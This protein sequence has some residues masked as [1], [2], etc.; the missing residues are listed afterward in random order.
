MAM[1]SVDRE[2][3]ELSQIVE[4]KFADLGVLERE[5]IQEWVV[6]EPT[7]L[8]EELLVIGT[9]YS[10]FVD[11]YER[12]DVIALDQ[13]GKLVIIELKRDQA[14]STT[15][16]Q[17]IKYA[18]YL[19]T[20]PAE[21]IQ[22]IYREFWNDRKSQSLAPE[23]VG[24]KFI[25]FLEDAQGI[26]IDTTDDGWADFELDN[27]P[28]ILLAAGSFGTEVTSPVMWLI[29]EYEMDITCVE[30][31]AYEHGSR[32]FVDSRQLIPIPEAEEYRAKQREKEKKQGTRQKKR[33][34]L[35]VLLERE[36]L[37]PGDVVVFDPDRVPDGIER[38]YDPRDDFW[39][40]EVT[41]KTGQTDNIRWLEDG[42][43]FSFTGLSKHILQELTGNRKRLNG[44][45]YWCHPEFENRTLLDLR[46]SD[47]RGDER[48]A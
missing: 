46:K 13:T 21:E 37:Q 40:A 20:W 3:H 9:E 5:D 19:S 1:F 45:K 34:S 38:E 18:S 36:V 14:D 39:R 33:S 28:R 6:E 4:R 17:A 43:E 7:I 12:P 32:L 15:D 31:N 23:D 2:A 24:E 22:K 42:Q 11:L 16:L 35:Y 41:G 48:I 30:L 47:V 10:Q 44:Y 26:E 27:R 29:E 8:G 25:T